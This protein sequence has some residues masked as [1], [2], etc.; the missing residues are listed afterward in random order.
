M[1]SPCEK[2]LKIKKAPPGPAS[3][4]VEPSFHKF[5]ISTLVGTRV[6][7][8]AQDFSDA[9]NNLQIGLTSIF[10]NMRSLWQPIR[11]EMKKLLTSHV[12]SA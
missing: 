6:R 5:V 2:D 4:V 11:S 1:W 12:P 10:K 9:K 8:S 7:F 3:S